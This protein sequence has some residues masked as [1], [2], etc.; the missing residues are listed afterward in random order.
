MANPVIQIYNHDIAGLIS[1][2]QRFITELAESSSSG[3]SLVSSYDQ[4][5]LMSYLN[6]ITTY[7]AWVVAN[8]QLDLPETNRTLWDIEPLVGVADVENESIKDLLRMLHLAC[9]ELLNCQSARVPS[10][11]IV[12]DAARLTS[13]V[14]KAQNFLVNYIQVAT[15]LD[16]PESSP[17][18]PMTSQGKSGV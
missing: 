11:L 16:L 15:P 9:Q 7:Q 6:S 4:I 1:R 2:I 3:V 14:V 8:P 17:S 13:Y 18:V 5:R 10:G 12:F